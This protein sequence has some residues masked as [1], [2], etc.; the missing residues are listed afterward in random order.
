MIKKYTINKICVTSVSLF[1]I[2]MFYLVPSTPESEVKIDKSIGDKK[3][4]VVYLMD[5]DYY[6]GR[7]IEYASYDNIVDLVNKK[8]DILINGSD[9]LNSFSPIIPRN[10][11]VNSIKVDK[12]NI[13]ID[14]SKDILNVSKYNEELMIESIIYT[15]TDINGIDNIY[16]SINKEPLKI[17]PKSN[18]EIPYPLNRGYGI[19][20]KYDLDSL[21]NITKT[22]IYFNKSYDDVEYLVPITKVMNTTSEKI[23]I[24]I[25]E[26]KSIVNAQYNL[27]SYIPNNLEVVSHE[28]ND[29]K[30]NLIFNEFILDKEKLV[31]LEEV[32][33]AIAQSIFDNYNVKEVV[34]STKEKN[35][36]ATITKNN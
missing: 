12:N 11:K 22:T 35:N 34:F 15:I 29:D 20:K 6:L 3:E 7:M 17:L 25:E 36:I 2:L 16:L 21:N 14:F 23:D 13:Y 10:T 26:L 5:K 30:M 28:V 31:V 24:I 32:K 19:N 18:K 27:N 4:V 9:E 1:L 8:L 33:Y